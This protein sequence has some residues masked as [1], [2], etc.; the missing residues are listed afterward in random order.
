MY[1]VFIEG[2]SD[3]VPVMFTDYQTLAVFFKR[4]LRWAHFTFILANVFILKIYN[5]SKNYMIQTTNK[6]V[7]SVF[8]RW[9][10]AIG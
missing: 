5:Y 7:Q 1:C 9:H 4:I 3:F 2:S 6:S 8:H 10:V